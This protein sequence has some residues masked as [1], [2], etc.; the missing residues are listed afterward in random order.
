M[1][2]SSASCLAWKRLA[3]SAD[4]G[5]LLSLSGQLRWEGISQSP[6]ERHCLLA[7]FAGRQPWLALVTSLLFSDAFTQHRLAAVAHALTFIARPKRP[8]NLNRGVSGGADSR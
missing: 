6:R 2:I 7:Q 5:L 8:T 3:P 4:S 1:V